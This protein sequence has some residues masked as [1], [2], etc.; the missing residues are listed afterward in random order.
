MATPPQTKTI[1]VPLD[2]SEQAT[3]ALPIAKTLADL[4][5]ATPHIVHVAEQRALPQDL[6]D[7]IG[8]DASQLS[9]SVLD[10]VA[11]N[12]AEAIVRASIDLN[13][14]A[15]VM[16]S[17]TGVAKR[18][19]VFAPVVEEVLRTTLCPVV[20]VPP[21]RG[22]VPWK[23]REILLPYDGTPTIAQAIG[24]AA[25]FVRHLEGRVDVLYA[26]APGMTPPAEEGTLT[27]PLYM[28]QQHYELPAWAH[29]FVE[30]LYPLRHHGGQLHLSVVRGEP[31][32]EIVRYATARKS[33]LVVLEWR[34][35]LGTRRAETV[36]TV[37]REAP[38][39]VMV[40]RTAEAEG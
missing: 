24:R 13:A 4:E 38:G 1:I 3:V 15:I 12:P 32:P 37:T 21:E 29:E 22:R 31:G 34:G 16:C 11:G 8:L 9:G 14:A 7:E 28:D 20:L 35:I 36:K 23:P 26:V 25:E 17:H 33:D 6:L 40:L 10:L 18:D 5:D 19:R 30:R 27:A 2:G 39:P